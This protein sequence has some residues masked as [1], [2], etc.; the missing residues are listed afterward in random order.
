[1]SNKK[2]NPNPVGAAA[3]K[4][5][6]GNQRWNQ[7]DQRRTSML[8]RFEGYASVTIP[9]VCLPNGVDEYSASIQ[10]D[11]TS[12]G[13]QAVNHLTNKIALALF[14]PG[15]PF[16]R[17]DPDF[18]MKQDLQ[19]KGVTDEMIR[20]A[21]VGGEQEAMRTMD[22]KAIR[23]QLNDAIRNLII[24]G[25]VILDMTDDKQPRVIGIREYAVKRAISG[26]LVEILIRE[27]LLWDELA[28]DAKVVVPRN[29][30]WSDLTYVEHV[31]WYRFSDNKWQ[32]SQW[33]DNKDLG[34]EFE[35]TYT[36]ETLPVYVLVWDLAD[37]FDYGTGL[38]ED[39]AGDFGTLSTLTESEIKAA[40]L[41][42]EFRW[43]ANP[44]GVGD[45]N[46]VKNSISGDVIPGTKDDLQ[47]VS[48]TGG[49]QNLEQI[50]SSADKV[51]RR[52]GAA[53]LLNSAVTR[54]AERVT[55]EEIR[56]Q[57]QELET[58]L[59][60]V[61][62]RLAVSLQLRI[63]IWLLKQINV[64]IK[65]TRLVPSIVTGLEALS[66]NAEAGNLLQWLDALNKIGTMQPAVLARLNI[67]PII[68]VVAGAFGISPTK[69][70]IP[71]AQVRANQQAATDQQTNADV[72]TEAA[73]AA[74]QGVAKQGT[75]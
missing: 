61:Y 8:S 14:R 63:A 48:L 28:D 71:E 5:V 56:L 38:V 2:K 16:F 20:D 72:T 50:S 52:I 70:V 45:I 67:G 37:K 69:Y 57:A 9:K 55:A 41:A 4:A 1:M 21:L 60:G 47:L 53:F 66:R 30:E 6:T 51:I 12:V 43:L 13:A 23:P 3:R 42:S 62:S 34:S 18:K 54:D 32:L 31:R 73:K 33:V 58:S 64:E 68:S 11:W 74:A 59:G 49:G 29:A 26:R 44:A 75:Q 24:V 22:Q 19:T 35:H 17:L 46:D 25:N 15:S 7:L 65:G 36:D 40:I 27:K 10:H 39:Y